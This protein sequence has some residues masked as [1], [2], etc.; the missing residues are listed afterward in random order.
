MYDLRGSRK[1]PK[2]KWCKIIEIHVSISQRNLL[3]DTMAIVS[4]LP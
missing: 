4:T 1:L 3:H 2:A